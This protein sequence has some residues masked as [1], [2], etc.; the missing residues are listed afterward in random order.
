MGTVR[1]T[2]KKEYNLGN[3]NG[4]LRLFQVPP[5][6]DNILNVFF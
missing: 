2:A 3:G 1:M 6:C 4:K 5:P